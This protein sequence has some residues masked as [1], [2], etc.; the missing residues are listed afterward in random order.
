MI[1][2]A[3]Q[4]SH[5]ELEESYPTNVVNTNVEMNRLG[6]KVKNIG[7]IGDF[8]YNLPKTIYQS[9]A[10]LSFQLLPFVNYS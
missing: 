1:K 4:W 8:C 3:S 2:D 7:K 10:F 5:G 6:V 9:R